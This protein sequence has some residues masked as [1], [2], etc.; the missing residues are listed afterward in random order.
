MNNLKLKSTIQT[1]WNEYSVTLVFAALILISGLLTPS[2][3][4][5]NNFMAIFRNSA[6]IG[7]IGLGMTFVIIA[8]GIDLSVGA[9][10]AACGV[11]MIL[12]QG[13]LGLPLPLAILVTCISGA[14][15]GFINGFIISKAKLPPFIVT[16]A[17]QV[18]LRSIVMY[19]TKGATM[20][21]VR[22]PAFTSIGN[23]LVF[24]GLPTPFF[25]FLVIALI[26]HII[27]SKTKLGTYVYAVGG[28][29]IA[30]RYT[31]IKVDAVKIATYVLIGLMAAFASIMEVSRMASVSP[32]VS[33]VQYELEAVISAIVGGTSF[34]GGKGKILGTIL[35]A[36]MLFIIS[37][38]LIHLNI[39]TY[40]SGAVKGTVILVAVLLQKRQD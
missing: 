35:G 25:I 23:G 30:A 6:A 19:L 8:G 36:I 37:N 18:L 32:T 15:I 33:G 38:M 16:L 7:V 34:S 13:S 5:T 10:F 21:G 4:S 22:D 40:L 39:S 29:E 14:T 20:R 24:G 11:I 27:L 17:M 3:F 12:M 9:N 1:T 2:F 31:G 26:M 28:N